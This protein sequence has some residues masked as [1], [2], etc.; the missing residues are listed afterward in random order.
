[1]SFMS[2]TYPVH[3]G[4]LCFTAGVDDENKKNVFWCTR[5]SQYEK[6]TRE[7]IRKMFYGMKPQISEDGS[8]RVPQSNFLQSVSGVAAN[9]TER[10]LLMK[11]GV[12]WTLL[13]VLYVC[14]VHNWPNCTKESWRL[15]EALKICNLL[16]TGYTVIFCH[17]INSDLPQWPVADSDTKVELFL[18]PLLDYGTLCRTTSRW[19]R[20]WMC[21]GNA[22]RL[23]SSIIPSPNSL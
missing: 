14:N 20:H 16:C 12:L 10:K 13:A 22:C 17:H 18:S 5:T 21:L 15:C 23:I 9:K 7:A 2:F 19:R 11:A 8:A 1:M 6:V 4:H 3:C